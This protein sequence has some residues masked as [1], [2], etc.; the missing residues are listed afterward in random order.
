M[1]N[2][3][4]RLAP[5]ALALPAL[6]LATLPTPLLAAEAGPKSTTDPISQGIVAVV[7]VALFV[8]LAMEAAHRV[9]VAMA[10]AALLWAVTYFTPFK[11][12][13]FQN[14]ARSVDMNVLLL[15]ASMM[16][17]VGVL[18]S[19]G[20]FTWA[21][22]RLL[23]RT[24]GSA[25]LA[26]RLVA[27]FTGIMSAF[28]DNVTT[29]IFVTPMATGMARR[30]GLAPAAILLPMVVASNIGGTATLIGDPPN[31]M[32]G[33]GAGLSFLE[34]VRNLTAPVLIM[35]VVHQWYLGWYY[36]DEYANA[37]G[38]T[39]VEQEVE[40][41]NPRLLKWMLVICAGIL[42]GFFTHALTGTPVAVPAVI[43]AAVALVV[44]DWLYL[45]T[46]KPTEHERAHGV[47]EVI[48]KD[49]EWPTLSFFLFLFIIVGAAVHTGLITSVANGMADTIFRV[50]DGFG[51]SDQATL[52]FAA[53]LI[54][55]VSAILS[56]F[57]DNIPYVAVSIPI[58]IKLIPDLTGNTEVLW[59][60][61]SLGAC[62]GGNGTV[63]GASANVTTVGLA[64]KQGVRITFRQYSRFAAP[65]TILTVL[66]ASAYV[67]ADIYIGR[68]EVY[69][70]AW[71]VAIA[72][73]SVEVLQGRRMAAKA[74]RARR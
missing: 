35:L 45:K 68:P 41:S 6:L 27:W 62:L 16:A 21:V 49:I 19:T 73:V 43:G 56:A 64:E 69:I 14:A 38:T 20:A 58:I 31:I 74:G 1:S 17:V 37:V 51:L 28:L 60:A 36:K 39:Q 26:S 50:R 63:V 7:I 9:L 30:M 13:S 24:R 53:V 10:S 23:A 5:Y 12:I 40:L 70:L 4:R 32:I 33:S 15:L 8:L 42:V 29:V 67:A 44:Q 11:L 2:S 65:I 25:R 46:H 48:E 59:W 34:F 22:G 47:L 54:C 55:W 71:A 3:P 61:L 18:K 52:L 72:L 66:I 57:I